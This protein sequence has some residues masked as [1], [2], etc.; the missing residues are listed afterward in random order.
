MFMGG[1]NFPGYWGRNFVGSVIGIILIYMKQ[2]IV[3]TF[4][5]MLIRGQGLPSKVMNIGTQRTMMSLKFL[6]HFQSCKGEI[7]YSGKGFK[8]NLLPH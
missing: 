5:G 1:Q 2:M 7:I 4:V 3:Y 8:T 6:F